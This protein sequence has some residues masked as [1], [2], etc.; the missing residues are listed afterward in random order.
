MGHRTEFHVESLESRKMM[1]GDVSA[2]VVN[3]DLIVT[4]DNQD[5]E[6]YVFQMDADSY[7]LFGESGTR[8]NGLSGQPFHGVSD[9]IRI[10]LR[11]GDNKL[12]LQGVETNDD[13]I[14]RTGNGHDQI[15]M[16]GSNV[17]SNLRIQTGR[18]NDTL[19][20][21]DSVV[22]GRLTANLGAGNDELLVSASRFIRATMNTGSGHDELF[23]RNTEFLQPSRFNLA[24]G[25]DL[26]WI[27]TDTGLIPATN[28]HVNGGRGNDVYER[29]FAAEAVVSNFE[30]EGVVVDHVSMVVDFNNQIIEAD[31]ELSIRP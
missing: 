31:L 30:G 7:A 27:G 24:S 13:L 22:Q 9:D 17:R 16:D 21:T 10:N 19:F 29:H 2:R 25:E 6:I 18:G 5:N 14:I 15:L 11:N 8:I 26:A 28:L 1:A 4:G 23:V 20:I 3:G 12:A